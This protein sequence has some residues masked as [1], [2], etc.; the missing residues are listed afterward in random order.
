MLINTTINAI[1]IFAVFVATGYFVGAQ[2]AGIMPAALVSFGI[3]YV[4]AEDS[5]CVR[6]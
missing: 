2:T 5:P 1:F 3:A 6:A 4:I